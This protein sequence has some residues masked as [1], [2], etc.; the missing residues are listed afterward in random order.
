MFA[1]SF[2]LL[3]TVKCKILNQ[4]SIYIREEI[5]HQTAQHLFRSLA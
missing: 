3:T 2:I 5:I 1:I 4:I